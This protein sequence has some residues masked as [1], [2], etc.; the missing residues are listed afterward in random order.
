MTP[1]P[2]SI[3]ARKNNE[4]A[5]FERI[6]WSEF[7]KCKLHIKD[8][9]IYPSEYDMTPM[10]ATGP[11]GLKLFSIHV[12]L[13][14]DRPLPPGAELSP[15]SIDPREEAEKKCQQWLLELLRQFPDRAPMPRQ[16]LIQEAQSQFPKLSE[17]GVVRALNRAQEQ[18]GNRN[19][20]NPGRRPKSPQK[21]PRQK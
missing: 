21:S 18:E 13:G 5:P 15:V 16:Q 6:A 14:A 17:R 10:T 11:D 8:N 19:W 4:A 20:S 2:V 7:L 3:A 1:P 9:G 12:A